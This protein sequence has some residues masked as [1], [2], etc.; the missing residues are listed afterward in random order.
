MVGS[1]V[2]GDFIKE[3][4][5]TKIDCTTSHKMSDSRMWFMI[6]VKIKRWSTIAL[7]VVDCSCIIKESFVEVIIYD[8]N[9]CQRVEC[10]LN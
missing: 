9:S 8:S 4:L 5:T 3:N 2:V 1:D 10:R 6:N 7:F